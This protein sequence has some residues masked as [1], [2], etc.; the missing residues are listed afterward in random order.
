MR[1]NAHEPTYR[2]W[3][4]MKNRC[5][6]SNAMDWAYYGA[7]G[8]TVDP[9]WYE[10]DNFVKDMGERPMGKT[11]E[12]ENG[13]GNYCKDNCVWAT[14]QEQA[15]NRAYTLDLTYDGLT[16]KT[17]EWAEFLNITTKTLYWRLWRMSTGD[18][19]EEQVFSYHHFKR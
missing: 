3:Q 9:H 4:M 13:A 16:M 8:I 1:A 5:L 10:Y 2:S 7:R 17:W 18:M 19:N 14:R 11:L 6:N 15:R 12:R